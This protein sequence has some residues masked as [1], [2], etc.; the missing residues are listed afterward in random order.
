MDTAVKEVP[1]DS[2]ALVAVD[3]IKSALT[4]LDKIQTGL[5][6]LKTKYAGVVFDVKTS[7]GMK[8]A[9]AARVEIREP[10]YSVEKV[11]KA[12][13]AP[14]LE[15]GRNIDQRAAWITQELLL[16][17]G[18][19][20][21]QIKEEEARKE[22]ERE[23]KVRAEQERVEKI[24]AGIEEIK[25]FALDAFGKP[26]ATIAVAMDLLEQVAIDEHFGEFKPEAEQAK[27]ATMNRL[28]TMH[29]AA[30]D[31]EAEAAK[32]KAEREELERQKAEQA[33]SERIAHEE[34]IERARQEKALVDEG[35][36]RRLAEDQAARDKIESEQRASRLRIE[37]EERE[38]R[39]RQ[40]EADR[41]AKAARE[42]EE[43]RLRSICEEEENRLRA[44]RERLEKERL[45][46][47]ERDR[48][49]RDAAEAKARAKRE[50]E[51]AA[52]REAQRKAQERMD[53]RQMLEAFVT[54]FGELPEFA[55]V[56]K[57]IE[58]CLVK[59]KKAA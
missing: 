37:Q 30:V 55:S 54:R 13:K 12:A 1:A 44:E 38:A 45:A 33:E 49:A 7:A 23:A 32:L 27:V 36:R 56:V 53:A 3:S 9:A 26:A 39:A 35:I 2:T 4:E 17:E 5:A 47:E 58:A 16:I 10:R 11:R 24:L 14:V 57:A 21:S 29:A 50:K 28:N 40:E 8:E 52:A 51:E 48:K 46:A 20:D 43:A 41:Q 19:I 22:A 6:E 42:A 31:Q 18:P 25:Q 34:A 15:L 59:E